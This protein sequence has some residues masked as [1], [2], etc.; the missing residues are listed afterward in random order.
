MHAWDLKSNAIAIKCIAIATFIQSYGICC[1]VLSCSQDNINLFEMVQCKA[2]HAA[3]FVCNDFTR[4]E[5]SH[6]PILISLLKLLPL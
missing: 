6:W 3:R 4:F 5:R 2:G 1:S